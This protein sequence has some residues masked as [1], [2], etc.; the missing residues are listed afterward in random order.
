[1][2]KIWIRR[3]ITFSMYGVWLPLTIFAGVRYLA[4]IELPQGF[5]QFYGIF[6]SAVTIMMTFYYT[7][8]KDQVEAD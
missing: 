8:R 6:S 4:G 5:I 2:N 1:M 3:G 7:G